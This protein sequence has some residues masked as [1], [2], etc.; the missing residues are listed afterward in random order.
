M[1]DPFINL[2]SKGALAKQIQAMVKTGCYSI[3]SLFLFKMPILLRSLSKT[4]RSLNEYVPQTVTAL[5]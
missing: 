5:I 4:Q 2:L 1:P 3:N